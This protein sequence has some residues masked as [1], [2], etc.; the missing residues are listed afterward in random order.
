MIENAASFRDGASFRSLH[1][2]GAGSWLSAIPTSGKFALKPCEFLLAAYLKLGLPLPLCDNIQSCECGRVTSD[3]SGYHQMV[4]KT[5][6]GPV[7]SHDS[8]TSVWSECLNDLKIHHRKEPKDRY[9]TSD[10]HPDTT[11]FPTSATTDG[12]AASRREDRKVAR[13]E[14][15]RY[16]G[17]L[18]VRVVLEHF[19]GWGKKAESYLDDLSKRSRDDF[20]RPNR[21]D[22]KDHWRKDL[23]SSCK[24]VMQVFSYESFAG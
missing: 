7:W 23:L 24:D 1:G 19:R 8:I 9:A 2:K 16:P 6:G 11:V 13:Y 4:C 17:G 15:E 21:A 3:S 10:S 20:G 5:G 18:A 22:F 12:V 14:K